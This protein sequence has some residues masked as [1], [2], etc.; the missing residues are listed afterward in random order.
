[1][2]VI[3]I[4]IAVFALACAVVSITCMLRRQWW[5]ALLF[6]LPALLITLAAVVAVL[7]G[8]AI[9]DARQ[10]AIERGDIPADKDFAK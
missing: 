10:K 2:N 4:L 6:A 3:A 1:M 5:P 8:Q 7:Q 9:R